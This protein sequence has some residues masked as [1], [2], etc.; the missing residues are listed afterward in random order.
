M[1]SFD[2]LIQQF[3]DLYTSNTEIRNEPHHSPEEYFES[4]FN[5]FTSVRE[6]FKI[7][8]DFEA[9]LMLSALRQTSTLSAIVTLILHPN[10]DV[11]ESAIQLVT[12]FITTELESS[13]QTCPFLAEELV[14]ILE[15]CF[16][17]INFTDMDV[18]D[19]VLS[20][21]KL[22]TIL[23]ASF[24]E[25][26]TAFEAK[27]DILSVVCDYMCV[28]GHISNP[29]VDDVSLCIFELFSTLMEATSPRLPHIHVL[30]DKLVLAFDLRATKK[31]RLFQQECLDHLIDSFSFILL[32]E[33]N[34]SSSFDLFTQNLCRIACQ[35]V[36][37][38]RS[39]WPSSMRLLSFL[40]NTSLF[41]SNFLSNDGD[42]VLQELLTKR[43]TKSSIFSH[44]SE[45]LTVG[46][47][48][49]VIPLKFD[50]HFFTVLHSLI[51]TVSGLYARQL[52]RLL[53]DQS[54]LT[55]LCNVYIHFVYQLASIADSDSE[56][57]KLVAETLEQVID[58]ATVV[59]CYQLV[60]SVAVGV[61]VENV[62]EKLTSRGITVQVLTTS[63]L[64][65]EDSE[66]DEQY[67]ER[68]SAIAK[69]L[70]QLQ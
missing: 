29:L 65:I 46:A 25:Y 45:K 26:A 52:A 20:L 23:S 59:V 12:E 10:K 56:L 53:T 51:L 4:D 13:Y 39:S 9:H 36:I 41:F 50:L 16:K 30:F 6:L 69:L 27:K 37:S 3:L 66:E 38:F 58:Y 67:R 49:Q 1:S 8:L 61:N 28:E 15:S 57:D 70:V 55:E 48:S 32:S 68:L 40:T 19:F 63:L 35:G 34:Q 7:P 18:K 42:L 33:S 43:S 47:Q 60:T 24:P 5:L 44:Y 22:C 21:F 2:L 62:I 11:S 14:P 54:Y 31:L 64:E 17:T